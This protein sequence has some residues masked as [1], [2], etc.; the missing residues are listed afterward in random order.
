MKQYILLLVLMVM[1]AGIHAYAE[2]VNPV[3][4]GNVISG[5]VV[6]KGG[7]RIFLVGKLSFK[8]IA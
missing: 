3:K 4:E 7:Q 5:H 8:R 2:D 1:G 6:E